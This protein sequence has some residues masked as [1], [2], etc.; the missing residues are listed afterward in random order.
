MTNRLDKLEREQ[1]Q[2]AAAEAA[3]SLAAEGDDQP[4]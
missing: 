2:R 3:G 4:G 1:L